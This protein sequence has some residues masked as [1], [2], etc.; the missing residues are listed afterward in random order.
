MLLLIAA[1][2]FATAGTVTQ[3]TGFFGGK[4]PSNFSQCQQITPD[5]WVSAVPPPDLSGGIFGSSGQFI[6]F[7]ASGSYSSL[8]FNEYGGG[9]G[10]FPSCGYNWTGTLAGTMTMSFENITFLGSFSGSSSG[11]GFHDWDNNSAEYSLP[12]LAFNGVWSNG[13]ITHGT[14]SF[15]M[16]DF[17]IDT[18]VLGQSHTD[19][20]C[21]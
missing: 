14:F 6:N 17:E 7:D 10:E 20:V 2:S 5:L 15:V 3:L 8:N 13:W 4:G 16:S 21:G 9:D 19:A 12:D 1:S 11:D 18:Q